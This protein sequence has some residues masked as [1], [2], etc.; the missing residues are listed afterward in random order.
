MSI[1]DVTWRAIF[2]I[3]QHPRQRDPDTLDLGE[4]LLTTI[5]VDSDAFSAVNDTF[6]SRK[7]YSSVRIVMQASLNEIFGETTFEV[8]TETNT[9]R[10]VYF[11]TEA[12][13][14]PVYFANESENRPVYMANEAEV[15][16]D[17]S[18]IIR[19]PAALFSSNLDGV[20]AQVQN[21]KVAGKTVKYISL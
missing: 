5:Q 11:S 18:L 14:L 15:P 19:V 13:A 16:A 1:F 3:A 4:S 8:E 6:E 20:K 12:E 7:K 9:V 17:A 10:F 21:L 2:N